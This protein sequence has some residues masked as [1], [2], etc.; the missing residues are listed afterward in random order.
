MITDLEK[1]VCRFYNLKP[2]T[3]SD[4]KILQIIELIIRDFRQ[5]SF[6]EHQW[7]NCNYDL[8]SEIPSKIERDDEE[9]PFIGTGWCIKDVILSQ[10][11]D[12]EAICNLD[13]YDSVR[14]LLM[15]NLEKAKEI[16]WN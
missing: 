1:E 10:M 3:I 4:K 16:I 11:L 12:E 2:R 7:D 13:F 5:I 8:S 14:W 6:Y 15:N 9:R